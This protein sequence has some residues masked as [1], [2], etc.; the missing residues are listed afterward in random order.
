M[1]KLD[2]RATPPRNDPAAPPRA[3]FLATLRAVL[4]SFIGVRRRHDYEHDARSLDPRA[5]VVAGLLAGL[6]FVLTLVA[7]VRLVVGS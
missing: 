1:Q 6:V 3:G 4:W 2:P 5:I 7:V